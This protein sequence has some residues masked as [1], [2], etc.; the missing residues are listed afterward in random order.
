MHLDLRSDIAD[1]EFAFSR[2][3]GIDREVEAKKLDIQE[4][5]RKNNQSTSEG[6]K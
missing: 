2:E 4:R 6:N 3:K 5:A 1:S